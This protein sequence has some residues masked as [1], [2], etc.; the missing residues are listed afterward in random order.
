MLAT[1]NARGERWHGPVPAN[2]AVVDWLSYEQVMPAAA[3]VVTT[4]GHGTVARS[5]A[6]GRPVLVWP[7][8][9]DT[10]E[11]GARVT[12]AGAGLSVPRRLQG[13]GALRGAARRLLGDPRFT[14]RAGEIAAWARHND[15]AARGAD[16]VEGYARR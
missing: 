15:G 16:L 1:I 8:G 3:L 7:A 14:N 10:A 11:N 9:A 5:L 4:G 13:R 12:W 6:A 2:A